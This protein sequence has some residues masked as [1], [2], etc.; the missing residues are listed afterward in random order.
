MVEYLI[1][2]AQYVEP[3]IRQALA[4]RSHYPPSLVLAVVQESR[5]KKQRAVNGEGGA[6]Y[7]VQT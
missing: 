6:S 3:R 5:G 4:K 7:S 2:T 1:Y